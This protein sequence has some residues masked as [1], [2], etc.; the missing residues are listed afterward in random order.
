MLGHEGY[1]VN[2]TRVHRLWKLEGLQFPDGAPRKRRRGPEGEVVHRAEYPNHVWSYDFLEDRTEQG[3]KLRILTVLDE[4]TRETL[5]IR[6]ERSIS[7]AKVIDS[8]EWL[9][10]VRGLP[11]HIASDNGPDF[12]AQAVQNWLREKGCQTIYQTSPGA[13]S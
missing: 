9:G 13:L 1:Q 4:F 7:S 8:L 11:A 12:V 3:N 10:L 5:K 6:V 2:H